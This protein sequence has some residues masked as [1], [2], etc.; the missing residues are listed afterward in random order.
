M[1]QEA[2]QPEHKKESRSVVPCESLSRLLKPAGAN[3]S[4]RR[5]VSI[6]TPCAQNKGV[7]LLFL[8]YSTKHGV[9]TH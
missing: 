9:E 5:D 6:V 7:W 3:L 8:S 2:P 4:A 1:R